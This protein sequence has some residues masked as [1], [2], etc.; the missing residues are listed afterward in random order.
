MKNETSQNTA[1]AVVRKKRLKGTVVSNAMQKSV[2]VAVNTL[3]EHG[4]YKKRY[5]S[6]SKYKAHDE[7]EA[8]KKGD[9]VEIVEC[10][11]ISRDKRW[12]VLY[13]KD[14]NISE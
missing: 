9:R 8:F 13:K 14:E 3:K 1:A 4:K 12:R 10:R 5:R 11:P 2:V 6:T 7:K